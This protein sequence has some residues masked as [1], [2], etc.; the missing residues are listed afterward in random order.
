MKRHIKYTV[1]LIAILVTFL[2]I[3]FS[4][5]ANLTTQ[6]NN[7]A[8]GYYKVVRAVD[9]DT[10]ELSSGETVRYIGIDTPEIREKRGSDWIYNPRPYAEDAKAFNKNFVEGKS[11]RLEFDVQRKDK[12]NRILAYVYIEDK[13]VN[14]EIVREGLAMIYTYPPN[15]RYSQK[16]LDAQREARDNK[17]GLWIDLDSEN[18]KIST[19]QAKEN[20]GRVRVIEAQ[21][22]DTYLTEKMLI[23]K[24]KNNFKV[25]IY[26]NNIPQAS[27]DMWRSPNLYFKGKIVKVY[28]IIKEYKG[29]PEIVLHDFSQLESLK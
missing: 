13:M 10:I 11:V 3:N 7:L 17:R 5:H 4:R 23:L 18:A 6:F 19:A 2:I 12:Y 29:H 14:V 27:Q 28:G 21:V 16:F 8:H 20:I 1:F 25:V 26:K 15:V 9:G 24:F 22:T